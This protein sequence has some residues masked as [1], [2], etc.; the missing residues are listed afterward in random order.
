MPF[1][2]I[3]KSLKDQGVSDDSLF[4]NSGVLQKEA[5]PDQE[6]REKETDL[7]VRNMSKR[8]ERATG[9]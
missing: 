9:I 4:V 6:T 5:L 3:R 7:L 2:R 1:F 8:R